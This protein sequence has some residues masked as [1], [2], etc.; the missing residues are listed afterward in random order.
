MMSADGGGEQ[1]ADGAG[2]DHDAP[3]ALA[4]G[5]LADAVDSIEQASELIGDEEIRATLRRCADEL[6]RLAE[7]LRKPPD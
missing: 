6:T 4:R 1:S 2:G 5:L 7:R 3:N